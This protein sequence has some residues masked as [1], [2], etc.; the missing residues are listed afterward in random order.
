MTV[1]SKYNHMMNINDISS[2]SLPKE[3]LTLD[4]MTTT[5]FD[6]IMEL[7]FHRL[8]QINLVLSVKYLRGGYREIGAETDRPDEICGIAGSKGD[9]GRADPEVRVCI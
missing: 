6:S 2:L 7:D 5:E 4:S 3:P 9:S 1:N 8:N